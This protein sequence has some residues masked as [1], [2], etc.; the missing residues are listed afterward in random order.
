MQIRR[1]AEGKQDRLRDLI[2]Y[3]AVILIIDI[4]GISDIITRLKIL[5]WHEL[6]SWNTRRKAEEEDGNGGRQKQEQHRH[7]DGG[8]FAEV[9]CNDASSHGVER[10]AAA[11]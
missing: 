11:L 6:I 7:D 5:D 10:S 9:A 3:D 8:N 2:S 1:Y 4:L